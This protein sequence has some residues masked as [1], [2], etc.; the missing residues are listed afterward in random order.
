MLKKQTL[1]NSLLWRCIAVKI[2][3]RVRPAPYDGTLEAFVDPWKPGTTSLAV[4]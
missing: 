3:A 2:G 1:P 4:C